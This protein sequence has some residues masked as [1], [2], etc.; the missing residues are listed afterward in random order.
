M[1]DGDN[2]GFSPA[3]AFV[4][5]DMADEIADMVAD[6]LVLIVDW[7]GAQDP[8]EV[9][10]PVSLVAAHGSA[11]GDDSFETLD[12][13]AR[14]DLNSQA[15]SDR[16]AWPGRPHSAFVRSLAAPDVAP[17]TEPAGRA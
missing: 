9:G 12:A 14:P 7:K 8:V 2:L 17:L 3:V 16:F 1:A 10:F 6:F 13:L 4:A 11:K 15:A 5:F